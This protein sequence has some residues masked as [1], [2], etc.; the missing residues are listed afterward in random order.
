MDVTTDEGFEA[1][2]VSELQVQHAA[3][4]FHQGESVEFAFVA[5]IVESAEVSPIDFKAFSRRRLHPQKS[6]IG[7][8]LR[9][10]RADILAQDTMAAGITQ[11]TQ[12]LFN[13][14][15]RDGGVLL[16]QFSDGGLEGIEFAFP[17][18]PGRRLRG[19]IEVLLDSS[20]I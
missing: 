10:N 18:P 13:K 9:A 1:L 8:Q 14:G 15:G 6:A 11:R 17:L 5:L 7:F 4:C 2:A 20:P 19:R 3:V 16:Q 12:L